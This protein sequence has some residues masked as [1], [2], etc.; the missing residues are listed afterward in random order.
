MEIEIPVL[1]SGLPKD[2]NYLVNRLDYSNDQRF[3]SHVK[4]L[5]EDG[6]QARVDIYEES[7]ETV[8]VYANGWKYFLNALKKTVAN[9]L[10]A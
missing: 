3:K 1:G 7:G 9:T 5:V 10:A 4:K 8:D 6:R 2:L